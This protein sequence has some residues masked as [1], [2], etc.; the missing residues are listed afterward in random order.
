[1]PSTA[2]SKSNAASQPAGPVRSTVLAAAGGALIAG[3]LAAAS[4]CGV[5]HNYWRQ[6]SP[7]TAAALDSPTAE[8]VKAQ[9]HF[10]ADRQRGWQTAAAVEE[11][12][13]VVHTPLYFEDPFAD[14]GAGRAGQDQY[15]IG[16][17]D[18]VAMLYGISRYHLNYLALPASWVVTPPWTA[19][20]SDGV[21][22]EQL[23][24][25]DHDAERSD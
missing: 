23:L 1:M 8:D 12:G 25:K 6:D 7:A 16:W 4:G 24:G 10:A 3:W 15:H 17:E 22:S 9:H 18:Y 2:R 13:A 19:M 11:R 5:P 14:K 20:E 21:L